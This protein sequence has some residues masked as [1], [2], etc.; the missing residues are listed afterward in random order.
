MDVYGPYEERQR[1][2]FIEEKNEKKCE[3]RQE[4]RRET[5]FGMNPTIEKN[6]F[7]G[8]FGMKKADQQ[9]EERREEGREADEPIAQQLLHKVRV[10]ANRYFVDRSSAEATTYFGV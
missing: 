8:C 1:R 5:D 4:R 3:V 6:E 7:K 9:A 2:R 10:D